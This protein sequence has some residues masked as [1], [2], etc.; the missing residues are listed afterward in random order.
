MKMR[1]VL[2][3]PAS[4]LCNMSCKY[5]FY[6]D[7]SQH[8]E[9][10]SFGIMEEDVMHELIV[11]ALY[12]CECINFIFQ[13]GEPT[14]AGYPY[15]EN[16]VKYVDKTKQK[17]QK[18]S[19]YLQTNGYRIDEKLIQLFKK[20][21]FLIGVSLDGYEEIHDKYR[22]AP[23]ESTFQKVMKTIE[24]LKKYKIEFNIL[25]VLTKEV[26]KHASQIYQFYKQNHFTH[27]QLIPC[28]PELNSSPQ[29]DRYA[30]LPKQFSMFYNQLFKLWYV[31]YQKGKAPSIYF[32][33]NI[34][35]MFKEIP[36]QLCGMLGFCQ[37][38]FVVESN[39][40]VYPCDFYCTDKYCLG[41]IKNYNFKE[42][43]ASVIAKEFLNE[44]R[45]ESPKCKTCE[46]LSMCHG[47]CKRLNVAY[48]DDKGYCGLQDF[49][50][51]NL[52]DIQTIA[53][54]FS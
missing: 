37:V 28:L 31:D 42:L 17:N 8:R 15:F 48:F 6:C 20:Y 13:G 54:H 14:L 29:K 26:S 49:L 50:R 43:S 24:Q 39:G 51:T 5:C 34:I 12:D 9:N 4:S 41:N 30:L 40:N 7:V 36:P 23:F 25:T 2:I 47:N 18:V 22:P 19:Y 46:F 35:P 16:F 44:N 27:I 10:F 32:F 11:K 1:S 52:K 45:R 3:K 21:N 38:Q 33:D 53:S